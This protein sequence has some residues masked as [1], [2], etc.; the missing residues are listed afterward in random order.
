[1]EASANVSASANPPLIVKTFLTRE[2]LSLELAMRAV[3]A[4]HS[5][6]FVTFLGV[7]R[8]HNEGRTVTR[9][10]YEAYDAMADKELARIVAELESENPGVSCFAAHRL[11]ELTV[12]DTAVL[13]AVSMPHRSEAFQICKELIDRIKARVPIW[14]REWGPHGA[15]WVGWED[16]RCAAHEHAHTHTRS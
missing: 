2:P 1:M 6:A 13:C 3:A 11:G 12:G 4:A 9:L 14:K 5:G 10:D 15:I 7:V 8:D 16:A